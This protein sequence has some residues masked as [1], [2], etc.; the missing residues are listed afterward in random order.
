MKLF[1]SSMR[2]EWCESQELFNVS[3]LQAISGNKDFT[4]KFVYLFFPSCQAAGTSKQL[5]SACAFMQFDSC[6]CGVYTLMLVSGSLRQLF[7]LFHIGPK[8]SK[9]YQ[10]FSFSGLIWFPRP[11]HRMRIEISLSPCDDRDFSEV[12]QLLCEVASTREV[13]DRGKKWS[14]LTCSQRKTIF[15]AQNRKYFS[16][17]TSG[18]EC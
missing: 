12:A 2:C 11:S 5:L 4:S 1:I 9:K 14:F 13:L 15:H 7:N 16:S 3:S 8:P 17:G 10:T 6:A 18:S